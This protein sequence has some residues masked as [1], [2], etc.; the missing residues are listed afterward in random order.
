MSSDIFL[1]YRADEEG[2]FLGSKWLE[3]RDAI[4]NFTS[5]NKK[6]SED[7]F[8]KIQQGKPSDIGGVEPKPKY[9]GFFGGVAQVFDSILRTII[10]VAIVLAILVAIYIFIRAR[11]G[12]GLTGLLNKL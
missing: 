9:E 7:D 5:E 2:S 8:R 10:I 12:K 1:E 3:R 11:A 4:A 6:I